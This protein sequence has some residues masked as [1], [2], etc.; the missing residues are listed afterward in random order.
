MSGSMQIK[1]GSK[2]IGNVPIGI[3]RKGSDM[4]GQRFH[5][6]LPPGIYTVEWR[7]GR[8]GNPKL[9]AMQLFRIRE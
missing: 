4:L 8:G 2:L 7:M 1:D 3:I 9:A 5:A 6:T